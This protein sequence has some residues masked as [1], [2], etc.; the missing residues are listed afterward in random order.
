MRRNGSADETAGDDRLIELASRRNSTTDPLGQGSDEL[1]I[2]DQFRKVRRFLCSFHKCA[3]RI[4]DLR[5]IRRGVRP[6]CPL[7]EKL[8]DVSIELNVD[9]DLRFDL[10]SESFWM[11]L[12][13]ATA[14]SAI[15]ARLERL[16]LLHSGA[17]FAIIVFLGHSD[18]DILR[19]RLTRFLLHIV[20]GTGLLLS[21]QR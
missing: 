10:F 4:V 11:S 21:V 15:D 8:K 3:E 20:F 1:F 2:V 17:H 5:L 7:L 13:K 12:K 16:I 6:L 14:P 9:S 18:G 19:F